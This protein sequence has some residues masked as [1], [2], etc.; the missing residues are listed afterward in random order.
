MPAPRNEPYRKICITLP[1]SLLERLR[2]FPGEQSWK[3]EMLVTYAIEMGALMT[4]DEAKQI[5]E[6]RALAILRSA[7]SDVLT[8][9][10]KRRKK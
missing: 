9:Q 4:K 6:D 1:D 5:A 10:N 7:G 3:I 8:E 2:E